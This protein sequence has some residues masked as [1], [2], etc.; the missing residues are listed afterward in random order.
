MLRADTHSLIADGALN[1]DHTN[2]VGT[3]A[4]NF[5]PDNFGKLSEARFVVNDNLYL[6]CQVSA[7]DID[8]HPVYCTVR[9]KCRIVK[10]GSKD[11]MAIAIQ[12][13][14]ADN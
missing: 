7:N 11:W 13:T 12:S 5:Y 1:I 4:A 14:A 3:A 10:L 6:N 2:N 9:I 8:A